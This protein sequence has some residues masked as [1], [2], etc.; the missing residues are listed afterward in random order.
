[1]KAL[2]SKHV[3]AIGVGRFHTAMCTATE[4]YTM[5]KNLGQLGC[6]KT[7]DT[8]ISPHAVSKINSCMVC[9]CVLFS[10][11]FVGVGGGH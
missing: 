9:V 11:R 3:I 2:K 1:M 8:Q 10:V 6:E 5:G 7:Y 4:V